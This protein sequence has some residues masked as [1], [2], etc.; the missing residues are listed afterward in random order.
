M[1]G[2][3]FI[4]YRRD[5]AAAEARTIN[6]ALE[7]TFG[8][9]HVFMDIDG[10]E[11]GED[12]SD[13]LIATMRRCK[14]VVVV[15][16]P[17]WL[18]LYKAKANAHFQNDIHDFARMEIAD[19]LRMGKTVLPVLVGGAR[20]PDEMEIYGEIMGL[21]R[22]QAIEIRHSHFAQDVEQLKKALGRIA[23]KPTALTTPLLT[24]T[25]LALLAG[26]GAATY[27][28]A[29]HLLGRTP[30]GTPTASAPSPVAARS[31]PS[32]CNHEPF[33]DAAFPGGAATVISM[34][35]NPTSP[36]KLATVDAKGEPPAGLAIQRPPRSGKASVSPSGLISFEPDKDFVGL[37]HFVVR[38]TSTPYAVA[39]MVEVVARGQAVPKTTFVELNAVCR[40]FPFRG[41]AMPGGSGTVMTM[42]N[43]G[44]A[45]RIANYPRP[46]QPALDI[47]I[48]RAPLSGTLETLSDGRIS[49]TPHKGFTGRDSFAY[50]SASQPYALS[51]NVVVIP[52]S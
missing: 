48:V 30:T 35:S 17:R 34:P 49:Y 13:K 42:R 51:V 47:A 32:E 44:E 29:P 5:D 20:M 8:R 39:V 16:G 40:V 7:Q 27:V 21:A 18:E 6:L 28:L 14:A 38:G 46:G 12:F 11:P 25:A 31:G 41:A 52:P 15:I 26:G 43:T 2:N 23:G 1:A 33:R 24:L 19:A 50:R 37:D 45:C 22:V 3:I 9:G 10:I 36:C 4:S